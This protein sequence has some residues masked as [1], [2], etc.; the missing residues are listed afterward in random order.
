MKKVMILV[1]GL[2]LVVSLM[3][4][5]NA[6]NYAAG[7][8]LVG[9]DDGVTLSQAND[10]IVSFGLTWDD[11][12]FEFI[13]YGKVYVPEGEEE[14]WIATFEEEEIVNYA[15]LNEIVTA[16][17]QN[18]YQGEED[19][20][21]IEIEEELEI[22]IEDEELELEIEIEE[23]FEGMHGGPG[24]ALYG[25]GEFEGHYK[26]KHKYR[27]EF[28]EEI[29]FEYER[30]FREGEENR[31]R[32]EHQE[33]MTRLMLQFENLTKEN[34][35]K[36]RTMLS[37][38]RYAEVKIMPRVASERALE[39]LRLKVCN[40]TNNCTIELKEVLENEEA[41][42]AYELRRERESKFLGFIK[43]KMKV[44]A[45]IDAETGD[46]LDTKKPWWAFLASEPTEEIEE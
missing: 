35:S 17:N 18:Q 3:G 37:N 26:F 33:I 11:S 27:D 20:E 28:G 40:E 30:E 9:F 24:P 39:R 22:E 25:E 41:K 29:E 36:I 31:F 32:F 16:G 1:I 15:E 43:S 34:M 46:V 4:I 42:L 21:E 14:N 23:E 5:V 7:E 45:R 8:I 12:S 13:N 44:S 6:Q 19:Y 10:L 2:F 38:G